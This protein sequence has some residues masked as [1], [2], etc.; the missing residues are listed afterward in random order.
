VQPSWSADVRAKYAAKLAQRG[1]GL[2]GIELAKHQAQDKVKGGDAAGHLAARKR[3]TTQTSAA[4]QHW[5]AG[6]GTG[7]LLQYLTQ[8]SMK[9]CLLPTTAPPPAKKDNDTARTEAQ[10]M[11]DFERQLQSTGVVIS[12]SMKDA[13]PD[14]VSQTIQTT[15]QKLDLQDNP[16]AALLVSDRD[17]YIRAAKEAGMVTCRIRPP[18]ARLGNVSA[19]YMVPSIPQVKDVVDEINGISFNAFL[20]A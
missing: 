2:S 4:G 3:A 19:H 9:I 8:R 17:E 14:K 7:A 20:K 15:L 18:N 1:A 16:I 6:T 5:M 12:L 11:E 10:R 13:D